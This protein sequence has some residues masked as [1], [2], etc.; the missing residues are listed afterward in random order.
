MLADVLGRRVTLSGVRESSSRGAALLAL[1]ATG[2]IKSIA[3]APAP[4]A[5]TYE[6]DMARH[7]HYRAGRERQQKLYEQ[8][9]CDQ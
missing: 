7:A 9:I 8:L 6:P 2:K 4:L 3:D 5:Q 1:E